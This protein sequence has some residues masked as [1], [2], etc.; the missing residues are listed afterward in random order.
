MNH[1]G[2]KD[3]ET[4]RLFLRKWKINDT[5]DVFRICGDKTLVPFPH[6]DTTQTKIWIEKMIKN[7]ENMNNY[8]W[9]IEL[10]DTKKIIGFIYICDSN[11]ENQLCYIDCAL[12]K[13]YWNNGYA[14]EALKYVI[15]YLLNN[16]GFNRIQCEHFIDNPAS[17]KVL[18]KAGMKY[19]GTLRQY[20]I[21]WKTGKITDSKVYSII[22]DDLVENKIV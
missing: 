19:E 22:K 7:Y 21:N 20:S 12:S 4:E 1:K 17:G 9:G 6:K 18:E 10:K 11:D 8:D 13:N 15:Q 5:D 16:I 3:I 2:T 14:T